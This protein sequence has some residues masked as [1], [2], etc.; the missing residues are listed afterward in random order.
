MHR[1]NINFPKYSFVSLMILQS[2]L[3]SPFRFAVAFTVAPPFIYRRF[4]AIFQI[5]RRFI[6]ELSPIF[7]FI[8][9]LSP[10]SVYCRR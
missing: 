8:A 1:E 6:T 5:Y 10:T 3:W 2:P 7:D 9:T 4:I